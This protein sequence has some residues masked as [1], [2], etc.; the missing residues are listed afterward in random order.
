MFARDGDGF[1][2]RWAAELMFAPGDEGEAPATSTRSGRSGTSS[3]WRQAG[4]EAGR[5]SQRC[6]TRGRE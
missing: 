6:N 3:T 1:R 2:H 5:T 4:A